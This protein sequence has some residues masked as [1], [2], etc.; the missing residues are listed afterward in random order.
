MRNALTV[1][2]LT[3]AL[4]AGCEKK[5][6]TPPPPPAAAKQPEAP[7][8]GPSKPTNPAAPSGGHHGEPVALGTAAL[9]E[10]TVRA[11]RDSSDLTPGGDAPIDVWITDA[12]GA[13]VRVSAVRFWIGTADARGSVKAKA[14]IEDPQV[15]NHWH[16]HAEIPDPLPPDAQLWVE[17]E[18]APDHRAAVA[19]PLNP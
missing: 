13:P 14:E 12:A 16:T 9:G 18:T 15:P 7:T 10:L 8:E 17:V 6:E 11:A 2:A 4:T 19:F 1:V 3:A 5:A